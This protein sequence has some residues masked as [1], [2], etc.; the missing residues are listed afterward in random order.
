MKC[1]YCKKENE[2]DANYCHNCG[3][4]LVEDIEINDNLQPEQ[5]LERLFKNYAEKFN[6]NTSVNK[7]QPNQVKNIFN[8]QKNLFLLTKSTTFATNNMNIKN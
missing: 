4:L 8:N 3:K 6:S 2:A 1:N 5:I 7:M